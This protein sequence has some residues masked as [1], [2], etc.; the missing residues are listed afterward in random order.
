MNLY[1]KTKNQT[2]KITYLKDHRKL[3]IYKFFNK[4]QNNK[5]LKKGKLEILNQTKSHLHNHEKFHDKI[6]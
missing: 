1:K 4:N 5:K 6:N 3:Q 2:H